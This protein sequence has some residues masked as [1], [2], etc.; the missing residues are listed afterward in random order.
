M[1]ILTFVFVV[2]D[3]LTGNS[4]LNMKYHL[5]IGRYSPFHEGHKYIIDSF[6]KNGKPVCIAIRDTPISKRD[7]FRAEIRKKTMEDQ[8]Q[9]NPLVKVIIIPDIESVCVGREVGYS[10]MQVPDNI[11]MISG[12]KIRK[13]F[14]VWITGLPSSGKT[15]I[16]ERLRYVLSFKGIQYRILDGD[17][18]RKTVFSEDLSFSEE[19]RKEHAKR[20]IDHA[21]YLN[22]SGISVVVACISPYRSSREEARKK[23][24][25]FVEVYL[26]PPLEVCIK[27]DTKGLYKK[28]IA[29]EIENFTGISAPYE[30]PKWPPLE[31]AFNTKAVPVDHCVQQ[32]LDYLEGRGWI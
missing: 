23:I 8:Y 4:E 12:T 2:E 24:P 25:N 17:N 3:G 1:V 18:L 28:A 22:E 15:T 9:G 27:R 26:H 29:G 21:K 32:I 7:P 5:F 10:I 31:I 20:I 14:T 30:E 13:A 16:A 6:V 19:D 11:K